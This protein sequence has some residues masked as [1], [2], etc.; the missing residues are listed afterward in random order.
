METKKW[1]IRERNKWEGFLIRR[2]RSDDGN[3]RE[4]DK[5]ENKWKGFWL[6]GG[7]GE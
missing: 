7:R 3:K 2:G 4:E 5:R 6:G 1:K